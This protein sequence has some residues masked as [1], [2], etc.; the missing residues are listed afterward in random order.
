MGF[1]EWA[2]ELADHIA[3]KMRPRIA[4]MIDQIPVLAEPEGPCVHRGCAGTYYAV[5]QDAC[6]CHLAPPCTSCVE[7]P[8]I[9][10]KCGHEVPYQNG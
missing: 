5:R 4:D 7:A 10:D 6:S 9:C 8:L 3:T 2:D 1:D